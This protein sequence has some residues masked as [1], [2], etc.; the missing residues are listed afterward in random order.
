MGASEEVVVRARRL[1]QDGVQMYVGTMRADDL[2]NVARVDEWRKEGDRERGY[3]RAPQRSRARQ[4]ASYLTQSKKALLP[5]SLLLSYRGSL[6]GR[7]EELGEGFVR[8]RLPVDATLWAV[9]GQHRLAGLRVAIEENGEDGLREYSL[10]VVIV[11]GLSETEEATQFRIINE[12]AKKV[13]TDLARRILLQ[14]AQNARGRAEV[15]KTGRMWEV[16]A[17][18]VVDQLLSN[19]RSPWRG[20]IQRP[21]E[22]RDKL[23]TVKELSFS[24]SLKPMLTAFPYSQMPIKSV[25]ERLI[26]YWLAWQAL[27]PQAFEDPRAYVLLKTPGIFSLNQVAPYVFHVCEMS[28]A[29]VKVDQLVEILRDLDEYAE[30]RYWERDNDEG[31]AV[32]GSMKGFGILYELI[33]EKLQEKG[34]TLE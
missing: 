25:T 18:D 16:R 11:E 5:T 30:A 10:A 2:L 28:G 13:R 3:Q 17:A 12:T 21:N 29:E 7:V 20:R 24:N 6:S 4:V 23:H 8:I 34:Y 9:D 33:V 1:K 32:Y 19:S 15:I 27:I 31:A 22:K 14:A 26:E